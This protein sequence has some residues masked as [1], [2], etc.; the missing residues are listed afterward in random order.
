MLSLGG[1]RGSAGQ[2]GAP[3]SD[4]EALLGTKLH[5]R[6]AQRGALK[7]LGQLP[8]PGAGRS[9]AQL[10]SATPRAELLPALEAVHALYEDARLDTLRWPTLQPLAALAA[11]LA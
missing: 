8:Q 2:P 11:Q 6:E 1:A 9:G 4:W 7:A 5:A 10:V 3:S